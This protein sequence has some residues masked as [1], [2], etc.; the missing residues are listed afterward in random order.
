M[1][2]FV[3][4]GAFRAWNS[5]LRGFGMRELMAEIGQIE[6]EKQKKREVKELNKISRGLRFLFAGQGR[7][8]SASSEERRVKEVE[9]NRKWRENNPEKVK[10]LR[11]GYLEK[12]REQRYSYLKAW[13]KANPAISR[14]KERL[15][16]W[17][18]RQAKIALE[19]LKSTLKV[20]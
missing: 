12:H 17:R 4:N 10:I 15:N 3:E 7:K 13:R 9:S 5:Q 8:T 16:H 18:T 19:T 20:A 14:L 2:K 1:Q 6:V 11:R